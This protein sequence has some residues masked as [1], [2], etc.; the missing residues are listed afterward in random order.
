MTYR[1]ELLRALASVAEAPCRA[2]LASALGLGEAPPPSDHTEVF[3]L[4]SHPYASVHLGAEGMLGGDAADRVAGFW[5]TL[6]LLPPNPPDHLASLVGL[7]SRLGEEATLAPDRRARALQR[8][9]TVLMWEHILSWAPAY[10]RSVAGLRHPFYA[11]WASTLRRALLAEG[12][13]LPE[14]PAAL[15]E[16]PG[17]VKLASGPRELAARLLSPVRSGLLVTR[18]D[19]RRACSG[20]GLALRQGERT[21]ILA[22]MLEQDAASTLKWMS[23]L[24]S[25]W[26]YRHRG[27][28]G[29]PAATIEAWWAGRARQT[30]DLL[31]EAAGP[32]QGVPSARRR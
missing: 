22:T 6:G 2:E 3:V 19:L 24:A 12:C 21:Y 5:R 14:L 11:P 10:L 30:A 29:G 31:A 15:R 28:A 1:P 16:A 32:A 27:D 7:Y 26:S 17:P 9:G 18:A 25:Q 4:Q 8:A 23:R 20:L 13:S